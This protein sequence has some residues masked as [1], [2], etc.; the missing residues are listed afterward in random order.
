MN[1]PVKSREI[2]TISLLKECDAIFVIIP[3][4][5]FL[6]NNDLDMMD[7]ITRKEGISELYVISSLVDNQLFG[8]EINRKAGSLPDV[9]KD[10]TEKLA[11]QMKKTLSN[12]K[13]KNEEVDTMFD[14]LIEQSDDRLILVSSIC[15][16]ISNLFQK[17]ECW[18]DSMQTV[19]NNLIDN[20]P[21]YF[22]ENDSALSRAS[23]LQI[24]NIS[25]IKEVLKSVRN[26]KDEILAKKLDEYIESKKR[27]LS[28]YLESLI[29]IADHQIKMIEE[30]DSATINEQKTALE[31][32][33]KIGS[34][35]INDEYIELI[36]SMEIEVESK[37]IGVI[38][39]EFQKY[40][41]EIDNAER[42]KIEEWTTGWWIW[43]KLHSRE[44]T[45]VK[46]GAVRNFLENLITDIEYKISEESN[47]FYN[48]W[49][50]KLSSE[51]LK[52]LRSKIDDEYIDDYILRNAIKTI[53]NKTEKPKI[54]FDN[55]LP[56]ELNCSGTLEG[57][58]AEDFLSEAR[59]YLTKTKKKCLKAIKKYGIN[60]VT[61]LC[62]IVP[63]DTLFSS[64]REQILN[65]EEQIRHR[66]A[67]IDSYKR[68]IDKIRDLLNE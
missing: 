42:Q 52:S 32:I 56:E 23:L 17:R 59:D 14:Q 3:A 41:N 21:D 34:N 10:I 4:G 37:L 65:L 49:R 13:V 27:C 44:V 18:D 61:E 11:R 19:W 55:E 36:E 1:D 28:D 20:Y 66:A 53:F 30:G 48:E 62:S 54:E 47:K 31:K 39:S 9:L 12:L 58:S 68:F 40:R 6:S 5:Q 46:A 67:S 24:S 29:K 16:T 45:T 50:K 63:S 26:K 51:L 8:S 22:S 60:L 2:R 35:T 64:I 38:Q 15:H 25:K 57:E 7:M 43:E 33:E